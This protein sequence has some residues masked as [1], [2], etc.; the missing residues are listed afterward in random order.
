LGNGI[1]SFGF[2][3]RRIRTIILSVNNGDTVWVTGASGLIGSHIVRAAGPQWHVRA[4]TRAAL[5]LADF[6]AIREQFQRDKPALVIHCAALSRSTSSQE[7]PGL[8]RKINLEATAVLAEVAAQVP[9]IFFSTDLVFDGKKGNYVE[10][11]PVNPL[12]VYAETKVAAERIVLANPL[13]SVLRT[14]LTYGVSPAGDRAFNEE[15][16]LAWKAGRTLRLFT[17]EF[18][19]PIPAEITARA[20]WEFASKNRP[21]LYHLAGGERLSRWQ[22]GELIAT[23]F[24]I[25]N[26]LM[27]PASLREYQG[28]PRSPDTSLDCSKIQALLG[29]RI[30]G[31]SDYLNH[32]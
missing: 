16:L 13:H 14:S 4:L 22:I 30:P 10:S 21:G 20:V 19:C 32:P 25:E 28:A 29:F 18:R 8:A 6:K 3:L 11:D 2:Q 23:R 24:G 12:S 5:D 31:L 15:M 26:P 7:Q 1:V 27:E 17:D 9:F